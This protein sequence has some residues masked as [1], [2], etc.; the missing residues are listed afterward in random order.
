MKT[1]Y[2]LL[3]ALLGGIVIFVWGAFSH[4]ALP[5]WEDVMH[6]F[7]NEQPV[8]DALKANGV[9]NGMYYGMQGFFLVTF[10][11][12][13]MNDNAAMGPLM[14]EEFISDALAAFVLAWLLMRA[15]VRG[16]AKMGLFAGMVGLTGWIA[17]NLS[18]WIWYN[19]AF[20]YVL[21][22]AVDQVIGFVLAGLVIA[23]LIKRERPGFTFEPTRARS[24]M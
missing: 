21:L 20:G 23:W 24:V 15:N 13:G 2:Y 5:W 14:I 6:R 12:Q 17:G 9:Q 8:V 1:K 22:E 16:V 10:F 18:N 4:M 7:P 19:F 11:G 3:A